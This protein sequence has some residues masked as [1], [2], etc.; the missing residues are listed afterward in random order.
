MPM[1]MPMMGNQPSA[2]ACACLPIV[3]VGAA[4][5]HRAVLAGPGTRGRKTADLALVV[6]RPERRALALAQAHRVVL[7]PAQRQ[8]VSQGGGRRASSSA[9][10]CWSSLAGS[11]LPGW[12]QRR[13]RAGGLHATAGNALASCM[14]KPWPNATCCS[15]GSRG[16][17]SSRP[18]CT[19]R[20]S[21][22]K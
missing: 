7:A 13:Q 21:Q 2:R 4:V 5:A 12:G 14:R 17:R 8:G 22:S 20:A 11:T 19:P 15:T 18:P 16:R 9:S 6:V 10:M 3:G 1:P